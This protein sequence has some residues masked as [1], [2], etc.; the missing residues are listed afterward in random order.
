M[1]PKI[2]C[3]SPTFG[4]YSLKAVEMLENEGYELVRIPMENAKN[5]A[6]LIHYVQDAQGWIVGFSKV[7]REVLENAP[8]LK[9]ATKHGT[10]TDNFDLDA[11]KEKNVIIAN[12]PGLNAN[13]VSDLAFSFILALARKIPYS[14]KFVRSGKWQPVM[15]VELKGKTLGVIGMGA[16]GKG[17]IKKAS[18]FDMKFVAFDIQKDEEFVE[19]Y[20]VR[21]VSDYQEVLKE[22]DFTSLHVP[23]NEKTRGMVSTQEFAMMKNTAYIINCARGGVIDEAALLNSLNNGE[24]AGAALD[25]FASEPPSVDSPL[26]ALDNVIVAPHMGAY[27]EEAMAEIS[28]VCAENVIRVFNGQ[29]P[30]YRVI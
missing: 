1:R 25:V 22:A 29:E 15:G 19:K 23:L 20:N 8:M 21:M 28:E 14:D 17:L 6:K 16:I 11:A 24:I 9:I 30:L 13:A 27:T 18:S 10:G 12:A 2:I 3:T 4:K 26:L 5:P 7:T